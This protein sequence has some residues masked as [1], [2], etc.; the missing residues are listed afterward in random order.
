MLRYISQHTSEEFS[1]T[2]PITFT[3]STQIPLGIKNE[4]FKANLPKR[5]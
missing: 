5:F 4:G 3:K 2:N 1:L